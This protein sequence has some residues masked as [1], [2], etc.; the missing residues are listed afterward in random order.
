MTRAF[1]ELALRIKLLNVQ[2]RTAIHYLQV[3]KSLFFICLMII[4]SYKPSETSRL[5]NMQRRDKPE[6]MRLL[7]NL[8]KMKL[9][10]QKIY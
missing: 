9:Q 6:H 8:I 4:V 10:D 2:L 1:P 7:G 3:S 5:Q